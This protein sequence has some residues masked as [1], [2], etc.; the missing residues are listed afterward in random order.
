M[1][2]ATEPRV[3]F[4]RQTNQTDMNQRSGR[5]KTPPSFTNSKSQGNY[6][7]PSS[8]KKFEPE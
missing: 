3:V 7:Y 8:H 6:Y 1:E 5:M 2:A 4:Q